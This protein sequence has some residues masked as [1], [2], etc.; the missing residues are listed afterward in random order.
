MQRKNNFLR[1]KR[2][3]APQHERG[4]ALITTLLLGDGVVCQVGYDD[5][6]LLPELSR[7]LLCR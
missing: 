3:G 5:Q 7:L 2:R 6:R 1:S 4:V